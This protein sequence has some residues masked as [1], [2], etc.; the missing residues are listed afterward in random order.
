MRVLIVILVMLGGIGCSHEAE[1]IRSGCQHPIEARIVRSDARYVYVESAFTGEEQ[2]IPRGEIMDIDHPGSGMAVTGLVIGG[3]YALQ[4]LTGAAFLLSDNGDDPYND[5]MG[6]AQLIAGGV[7][8]AIGGGLA[9]WGYSI[10]D[11]SVEAA[12][13]AG[14][15]ERAVVTPF[16]APDGSGGAAAGAGVL[17][18]W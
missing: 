7:G 11:E 4:A 2:A 1:I 16:V 15:R 3:T 17:W 14:R 9:L 18:R 5:F 13:R 10:W 6:T 12:R 8:M